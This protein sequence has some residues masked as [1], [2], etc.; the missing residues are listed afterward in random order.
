LP[1][2]ILP[3]NW[4][5]SAR[6]KFAPTLSWEHYITVNFFRTTTIRRMLGLSHVS[7]ITA[8]SFGRLILLVQHVI[9]WVVTAQMQSGKCKMTTSLRRSASLSLPTI[10]AGAGYTVYPTASLIAL[11]APSESNSILGKKLVATVSRYRQSTSLVLSQT[12]LTVNVPLAT[13]WDLFTQVSA[14]N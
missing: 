4:Q 3:G 9:A 12:Q 7:I 1:I 5:N 10:A 2:A 6:N 14:A 11:A 13:S 8:T